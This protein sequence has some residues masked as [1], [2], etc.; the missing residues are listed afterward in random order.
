MMKQVNIYTYST[1]RSPKSSKCE[2]AGYVIELKTA[3]GPATVSDIFS[4]HSMTKY[5][6]E[7]HV[8]KIALNRMN[9][10]CELHIYTDST[11]IAAGFEKWLADWKENDWQTKKKEPVKNETEWKEL[12][13]LVQ[14]YGHVLKFHVKEPHS[15]REW[16]KD[17]VEKEKKKC[18]KN[19]ESSTQ[20]K[21]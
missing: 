21:K 12:D 3:K 19:L 15:Y 20:Q 16:L 4:V 10:L 8:L 14:K 5:Q 11:Y 18:L 9:T 1:A 13:A 17:N 6:V 2:S 7:M